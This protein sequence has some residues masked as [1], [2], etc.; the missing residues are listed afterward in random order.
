MTSGIAHSRLALC[1]A[2]GLIALAMA[3]CK[4]VGDAAP[5]AATDAPLELAAD[6]TGAIDFT[7]T[8]P[9]E[10]YRRGLQHFNRGEYGLA[11]RAFRETVEKSPT[12]IEAWIGLAGSYDHVRRFDL[13]DRAYGVAIKLGGETIQILNNQGYS[14]MLRAD[15]KTARAKF[16]KAYRLD[17]T[18]TTIINNIRLLNANDPATRRER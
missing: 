10:T 16:R 7:D 12:N 13:A 6:T 5:S 2:A 17:P 3:G 18:N 8:L 14:Y 4:T 1:L 15:F 11:E 9:T